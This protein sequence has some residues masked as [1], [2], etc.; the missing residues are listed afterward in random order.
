MTSRS[1]LFKAW[2]AI[3]AGLLISILSFGAEATH[4]QNGHTFRLPGKSSI[5]VSHTF[6][7]KRTTTHYWEAGPGNGPL[8][9]FVHGWPEIG[10]AWRA[11]MEAFAAEGWRCIAPDLR[12]FGGS[13]VPTAQGAH[14]MKEV[15]DDMVELHAHL[16][17]KAA[18]WVGHDWGSPV[19]SSLVAHYPKISRGVVLVSVPYLPNGWALPNLIPLIDRTLYP[20]DKY[21]DGQWDY[22]RFYL[23]HFDQAVSD[24]DADIPAT[25]ASIFTKGVPASVGKLS[26]SAVVTAH[27][28]RYGAAHRAPATAPDYTLWPQADF[29]ALV[30][31]FKKTGFRP[32]NSYY[33][34]D[35]ANIAYA[36]TAVNNGKLSV[37][38]LYVND[39]YEP[40]SNINLS[41]VG[42]PMRKA[43]SNLTVIDQP[44]GHWV[45][46]E[47]KAELTDT[48]RSWLKL[49]GLQ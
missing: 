41:K 28:G 36:K 9:I 3:A 22:W 45:T 23:T 21:P 37:P 16:G 43:C 10:L 32:A 42:D 7:S 8:M 25:L 34:N 15:V 44:S 24:M 46:L 29:D 17:G 1:N 14:A 40:F 6:T 27:G 39:E 26:P 20:A 49:M 5:L 12:G 33:L 2:L 11:Q 19:V 38:V 13:S 18:I 35:D 47:R 48:I 30:A 4:Q 31:A